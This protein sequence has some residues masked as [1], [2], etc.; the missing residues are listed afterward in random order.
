MNVGDAVTLGLWPWQLE[1]PALPLEWRVLDVRSDGRAVLICRDIIECRSFHDSKGDITWQNSNLR[2]WLNEVFFACAFSEQ[3]K[4]RIALEPCAAEDNN[5][6]RTKGGGHTEDYVFCL[7]A[8]QAQQLFSAD[9]FRC[10]CTTPYAG[11]NTSTC[12]WWLRTPGGHQFSCAA[13]SDTGA[14]DYNGFHASLDCIGVRPALVLRPAAGAGEGADVGDGARGEARAD[15]VDAAGG[16]VGADGEGDGAHDAGAAARVGAAVGALGAANAR[17]TAGAGRAHSAAPDLPLFPHA[18]AALRYGLVG[19]AS[20]LLL[21]EHLRAETAHV[22]LSGGNPSIQAIH[23]LLDQQKLTNADCFYLCNAALQAGA[24][25]LARRL[26]LENS[27]QQIQLQRLLKSAVEKGSQAFTTLLLQQG[28]N[29][30]GYGSAYLKL[31][32]SQQ[33]ACCALLAQPS[34]LFDCWD[35]VAQLPQVVLFAL[36]QAK[37][38]CAN[39]EELHKFVASVAQLPGILPVLAAANAEAELEE[40]LAADQTQHYFSHQQYTQALTA[41][42]EAGHGAVVALLL[43]RQAARFGEPTQPV[44]P[45]LLL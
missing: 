15:G 14:V 19:Q 4:S 9:A 44:R 40:V 18:G 10:A 45:N 1:G 16:A 22:A 7:S 28:A 27:F 38:Q 31:G 42:K 6:Y 21:Q 29:G 39:D 11:R 33:V 12:W 32:V 43:D 25:T 20:A 5:Y 24:F 34:A 35:V 8:Q 26:V 23:A 36:E 17:G 2:Y 30:A 13:V 37:S 3:E 41:A